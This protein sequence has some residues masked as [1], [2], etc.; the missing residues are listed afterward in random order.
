LKP[1]D[2]V[3]RV[4]YKSAPL[5]KLMKPTPQINSDQHFRTDKRVTDQGS[6][7]LT[8]Y[9]FQTTAEIVG[10]STAVAQQG[11]SELRTFRNVSRDFF[12][13]EMTRDYVTEA[14]LFVSMSCAAAWPMGV[15][16]HQLTRWM[17]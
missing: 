13:G 12:G 3:R 1:T 11:K 6:F 17:I 14:L 10:N 4:Y 15:M 16:I 7:P 5:N 8:D 9:A 2:A